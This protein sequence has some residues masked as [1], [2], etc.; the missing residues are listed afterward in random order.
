MSATLLRTG[1]IIIALVLA[2]FIA[3]DVLSDIPAMALITP[4]LLAQAGAVGLVLAAAGLIMRPFEKV[5]AH[6]KKKCV[7]CRKPV[8]GKEMYCREHLRVMLE[9]EDE[10]THGTRR[11]T[12]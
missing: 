6:S 2:L 11:H 7:V 3:R 4:A 10:R 1:L 9:E 5:A 8:F 12:P